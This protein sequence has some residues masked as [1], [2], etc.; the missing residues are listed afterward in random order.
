M[1]EFEK[2]SLGIYPTP[3]HKLP[4]LSRELGTNVW[5][6]RDDLC[7]VALGGNKV[8]KLEFLLADAKKQGYDLVMTTGAAQSNHAMLTA[9][10]CLRMGLDCILVLKNHGITGRKGNQILNYLMGV[11]VRFVDTDSYDDIYEEMDRIA[12]EM[13]RKV[14]KIPCGGSNALGSL[15]YV[16]CMREVSEYNQHFEHIVCAC[17]SGGTAAGTVLGAKLYMPDTHVMC[18]MVD[19]DPFDVI[20]PELMKEAADLLG[21][22]VELPVL[23]LLDMCGPG[24]SIPSEEG[25][26]AI[27]MMMKLEGI[28]L[29]TCYTG[30]AFAGL[31]KRAREGY[32]KPEDNVLF[33]H[34]GG[35]GGLFAQDWEKL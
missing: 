25:N 9:A 29:D 8:R 28:V 18:S 20:V 33:V 26:E 2:V 17:G 6:K 10:C 4:N 30:K 1:N 23:D 16:D 14:Y 27:S 32:Y 21:T 12:A 22:D 11:E 24:Y 15:G 31:I 13:G 5:I 19:N 35:A 3:I 7:G 34:S